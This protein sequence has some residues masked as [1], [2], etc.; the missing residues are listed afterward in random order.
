MTRLTGYNYSSV[1]DM[2]D[3]SAV[4]TN[5]GK[6]VLDVDP[7]RDGNAYQEFND[8]MRKAANILGEKGYDV[9]L[10]NTTKY[11][12]YQQDVLGYISWGSNDANSE[13]E[14]KTFFNWI[15]GA[16]A[17]TAVSSSAR[18]FEYPPMYGQSL[19]ADLIEEGATG[20]NGFVY[21][22]YISAVSVPNIL[23]DRYTGGYNLAESYYMSSKYIGWM[24]VVVGDPKTR[25]C[26]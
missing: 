4:A 6:F 2:I 23:F 3:R 10:D 5:K 24:Q 22:P 20:V 15:P 19:V 14:S 9:V 13:G 18:T 21:E 11:L 12:T 25:I 8:Q 17:E 16:I 26:C 1:R 7:T